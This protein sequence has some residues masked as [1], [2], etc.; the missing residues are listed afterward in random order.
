MKFECHY[1][2]KVEM[3]F[4][5]SSK[6]IVELIS[7]AERYEVSKLVLFGSRARGDNTPKSDIDISIYTLPNFTNKG[8]LAR[9]IDDLDTL[10]KIDTLFIESDKKLDEKLIKNIQS[11][12]VLIYKRL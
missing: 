4:N 12:G 5:L 1:R 8:G 3:S 2:R 10:L 6:I 11:E 9:D 7:I